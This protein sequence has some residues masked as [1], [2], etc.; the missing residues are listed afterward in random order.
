MMMILR[1]LAVAIR[2]GTQGSPNDDNYLGIPVSDGIVLLK[3]NLDIE[4]V[5]SPREAL[6]NFFSSLSKGSSPGI[7]MFRFYL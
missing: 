7:I 5:K 2:V 1:V 6:G 3:D 4:P